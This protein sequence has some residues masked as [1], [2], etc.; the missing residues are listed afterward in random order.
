MAVFGVSI[1]ILVLVFKTPILWL[2]GATETVFPYASA[3]LGITAF[4][5][6][7]LLMGNSMSMLI[8]ADGSPKYSMTCNIVGAILNVFLD[9]LFLFVFQWGIRGA[10]FATIIG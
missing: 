7:F 3:Y 1:M 5:F 9:A 4:G 8:R 2:C 10:A 6:P